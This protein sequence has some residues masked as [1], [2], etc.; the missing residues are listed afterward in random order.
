MKSKLLQTVLISSIVF[1]PSLSCGFEING[2]P[3]EN[4][5]IRPGSTIAGIVCG[6]IIHP[7][8]HYIAA[9]MFGERI[10]QDGFREIYYGN[11]T[12]N[13]EAWIGRSGF[14]LQLITGTLINKTKLPTD[15]KI[16]YNGYSFFSVTTYPAFNITQKRGAS[17][18]FGKGDFG[19]IEASGNSNNEYLFYFVWASYN[20]G[21]ILG[22]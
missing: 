15:F 3:S 21:G 2:V 1:I 13:E 5:R 12:K 18:R 20:L 11:P 4:I 6:A 8:G 7:L 10:G 9:E 17:S 16:G 14:L 19:N 22:D